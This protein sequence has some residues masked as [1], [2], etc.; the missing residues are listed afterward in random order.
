MNLN[1]TNIAAFKSGSV[2]TGFLC[3]S[4]TDFYRFF[5]KVLNTSTTQ[6]QT[7]PRKSITHFPC[8]L[9]E[10]ATTTIHLYKTEIKFIGV[11]YIALALI[12]TVR[13]LIW[14][15]EIREWNIIFCINS[16]YLQVLKHLL[17]PIIESI[18]IRSQNFISLNTGYHQ[19]GFVCIRFL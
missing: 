18:F 1:Q 4:G 2:L 13:K 17:A 19:T 12:W 10:L 5:N 14:G 9:N 11:E 16:F 15:K 8:H 7:P 6:S 3:L